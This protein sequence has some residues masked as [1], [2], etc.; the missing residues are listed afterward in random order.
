[1]Q[2]RILYDQGRAVTAFEEQ[3]P[4]GSASDCATDPLSTPSTGMLTVSAGIH[5]PPEFFGNPSRAV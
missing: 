5:R 3:F 1:M 2:A 4:S